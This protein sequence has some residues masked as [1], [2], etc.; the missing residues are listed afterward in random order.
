[1]QLLYTTRTS[2]LH[3]THRHTVAVN[4]SASLALGSESSLRTLSRA[5]KPM[6][7]QFTEA[8]GRLLAWLTIGED[9]H[10]DVVDAQRS[11]GRRSTQIIHHEC[12]CAWLQA[13]VS[14][15]ANV[16]WPDKKRGQNSP[17]ATDS[18]V[19]YIDIDVSEYLRYGTC[20]NII[21]HFWWHFQCAGL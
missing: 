7:W 19:S 14:L 15:A 8:T 21:I 10:S 18:H 13:L 3:G 1:M 2:A 12:A 6:T 9:E 4:W 11:L 5:E 20:R 16:A 17:Q